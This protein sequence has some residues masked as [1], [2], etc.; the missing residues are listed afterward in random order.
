MQLMNRSLAHNSVFKVVLSCFF[1]RILNKRKEQ[2][3]MI[4]EEGQQC[5]FE[6]STIL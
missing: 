1:S 2:V 3:M 4:C 6:D 5:R